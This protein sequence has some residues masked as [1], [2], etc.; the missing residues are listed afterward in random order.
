MY[1]EIR[2]IL[3]FEK[4]SKEDVV[5]YIRK[6]KDYK[7]LHVLSYNYNWDNGFEIPEAII[8]NPFCDLST[9]MMVFYLADGYSFLSDKESFDESNQL[10][11]KRFIKTLSERILNNEY[12][13]S[14][15]DF[16][17]P[18]T[19]LQLYKLKKIL[20]LEKMRLISDIEGETF[21]IPII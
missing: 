5:D 12:K 9:A 16:K 20:N 2:D 3:Y 18:L 10:E 1:E 4:N 13:N 11:W 6:I 14:K 21:E 7:K 8:N 19:K 17:V 15:I